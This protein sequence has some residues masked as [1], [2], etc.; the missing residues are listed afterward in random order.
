MSDNANTLQVVRYSPLLIPE[1]E[2]PQE[3]TTPVGSPERPQETTTPVG[4]PEP[5]GEK[6]KDGTDG[7]KKDGDDGE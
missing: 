3:T 2:R 5:E 1:P 7:E 6:K 4:S